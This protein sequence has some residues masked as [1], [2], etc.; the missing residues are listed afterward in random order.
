MMVC[1]RRWAVQR[2]EVL[3]IL[4]RHRDELRALG[5]RSLALF[6]STARNEARPDSDVDLLV[7]FDQPI[8]LFHFVGVQ[9]RLSELLGGVEVDLVMRESVFEELKED[10]YGEAVNVL[11]A[12]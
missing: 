4:S 12:T 9:H 5:V 7:E 2:E 8:G 3:A 6:G 11:Q 1:G 10:I